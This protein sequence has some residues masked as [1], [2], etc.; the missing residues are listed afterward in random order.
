M[1]TDQ[2][3]ATNLL[4]PGYFKFCD[5]IMVE[6]NFFF[7]NF[8]IFF[9]DFDSLDQMEQKIIKEYEVK[10]NTWQDISN[11]ILN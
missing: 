1:L 8:K 11:S 3:V 4:D 5:V 6:K 9:A 2:S 7:S 10:L